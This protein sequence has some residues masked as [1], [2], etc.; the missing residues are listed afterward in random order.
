MAVRLAMTWRGSKMLSIRLLFC[1]DFPVLLASKRAA[2]W[3]DELVLL[4]GISLLT[5]AACTAAC[6]CLY[7]WIKQAGS[8]KEG[9]HLDH[10]RE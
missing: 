6:R 7:C 4:A 2:L 9:E 1:C 8:S 5:P 10:Q 3:T